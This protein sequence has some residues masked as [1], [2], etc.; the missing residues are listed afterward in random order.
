MSVIS[1]LRWRLS[2]TVFDH[3]CAS[4]F[5]VPYSSNYSLHTSPDSFFI[6]K[7]RIENQ[8]PYVL[9]KVSTCN[10]TLSKPPKNKKKQNQ[11]PLL[12]IIPA[13]HHLRHQNTVGLNTFW[14][15]SY[16]YSSHKRFILH[17]NI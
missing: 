12:S 6:S 8:M 9:E 13:F 3:K 16:M 14:I 7:P 2:E 11:K 4:Y 5:T 1:H 15:Y 17:E 10:L